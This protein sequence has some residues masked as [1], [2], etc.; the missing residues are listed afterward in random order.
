MN[1]I[2]IKSSLHNLIDKIDDKEVLALHLKLLEREIR[3]GPEDKFTPHVVDL[4]KRAAMSESDIAEGNIL[5]AQE[6]KMDVNNWLN[7]K[8]QNSK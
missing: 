6:F 4:N 2:S 7:Q 5:N 3:K 8:K 1:I